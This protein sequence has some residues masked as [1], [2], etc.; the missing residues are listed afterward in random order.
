MIAEELEREE[1]ERGVC[2]DYFALMA[3]VD[4]GQ[5]NKQV[6]AGEREKGR[7]RQGRGSGATPTVV[8]S[9]ALQLLLR[10]RRA[11]RQKGRKKILIEFSIEFWWGN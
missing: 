1:W 3:V 2:S 4:R 9:A 7:A 6:R 5:G 11:A 10:R 8:S